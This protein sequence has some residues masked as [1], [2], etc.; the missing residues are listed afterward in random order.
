MLFL[1]FL[2]YIHFGSTSLNML[3]FRAYQFESEMLI[4]L[5]NIGKSKLNPLVYLR[6]VN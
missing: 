6:L 2:C 4:I 1:D 5:K 3:V